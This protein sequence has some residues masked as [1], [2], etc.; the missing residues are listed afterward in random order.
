MVFLIVV[1]T[2]YWFNAV[3]YRVPVNSKTAHA[4]PPREN[5]GAFERGKGGKGEDGKVN[6]QGLLSL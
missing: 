1:F 5:P 2:M 6:T 4:P 3:M